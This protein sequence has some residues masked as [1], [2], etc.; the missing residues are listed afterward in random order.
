VDVE[1]KTVLLVRVFEDRGW[2]LRKSGTPSQQHTGERRK[3]GH[4]TR[5]EIKYDKRDADI[6]ESKG[7][8][9]KFDYSAFDEWSAILPL[10]FSVICNQPRHLRL[11]RREINRQMS[12]QPAS[13]ATEGSRQHY[14]ARTFKPSVLYFPSRQTT[15]KHRI[16]ARTDPEKARH[17]TSP[18]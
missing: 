18:Q 7:D 14:P 11:A 4:L 16:D 17:E 9:L 8:L 13:V 10:G 3:R 6:I 1:L 12:F 15:P 2:R 5:G